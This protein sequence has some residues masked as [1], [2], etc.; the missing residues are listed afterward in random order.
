MKALKICVSKKSLKKGQSVEE[1]CFRKSCWLNRW[2]TSRERSDGAESKGVRH[3][4]L[5]MEGG[6]GSWEGQRARG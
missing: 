6:G 5:G 2:D 3:F 1:Q 4:L